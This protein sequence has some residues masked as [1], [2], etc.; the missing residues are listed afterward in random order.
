MN[1]Y[2]PRKRTSSPD[3][4]M[5]N[6]SALDQLLIEGLDSGEPLQLNDDVWEAMK[7][8]ILRRLK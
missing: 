7:N 2:D 1:D 4:S 8:E 3:S 6:Q 5:Q